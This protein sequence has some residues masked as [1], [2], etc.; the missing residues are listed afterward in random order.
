MQQLLLSPVHLKL[1]VHA[2]LLEEDLRVHL[3]LV[4]LFRRYS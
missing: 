2:H 3:G 4:K 1:D